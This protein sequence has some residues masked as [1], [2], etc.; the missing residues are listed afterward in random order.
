M[1]LFI[2]SENVRKCVAKVFFF[3]FLDVE[4][5]EMTEKHTLYN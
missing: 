4:N 2:N 3:F 5:V 1:Q